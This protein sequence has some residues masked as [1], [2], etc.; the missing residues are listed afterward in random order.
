MFEEEIPHFSEFNEMTDD[1]LRGI[2]IAR[3][4]TSTE[5]AKVEH[6]L[7]RIF[8]WAIVTK[9]KD[10][11]ISSKGDRNQP[12]VLFSIDQPSGL[13][14]LTYIGES[15]KT[16][17]SKMF[18]LTNTPQG[19]STTENVSTRFSMNLPNW[20]A[21]KHGLEPV[22]KEDYYI[23]LRV[24]YHRTFDG[25]AFVCRLLD[26]Q[27]A[28][29]LNEFGL[30][31]SVYDCIVRTIKMP[32]GLVIVSGPPGSGKSTLLNAIVHFRNDGK[33]PIL[34]IED[35]VEFRIRS[36]GPVN[37]INVGGNVTFASA[38]KASLRMAVKIILVGEI[39]DAETMK[40]ALQATQAGHLVLA[41]LHASNAIETVSRARD[42]IS[43]DAA[44]I[45]R[46]GNALKLVIAARLINKYEGHYQGR[47]V[48]YDEKEWLIDNGIFY[49]DPNRKHVEDSALI[50]RMIISEVFSTQESK[51]KVSVVE[52]FTVDHSI[53][54]LIADKVF[55]TDEMYKKIVNQIQYES[56]PLCGYRAVESKKCKLS[57]C[58]TVLEAVTS[59]KVIPNLR[60]K[61]AYEFELSL[62]EVNE[63]IENFIV[64]RKNGSDQKVEYFLVEMQRCKR[65]AS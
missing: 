49:Q 65:L 48:S 37:Q 31:A 39:R 14:N 58:Q 9:S 24:E 50:S 56:L 13:V 54:N 16:F 12:N 34:T 8:V 47:Q 38:L 64:A 44:E 55:N 3:R 52:A 28:P 32:S 63:A 15:G 17:E 11:H 20:F 61:Y 7:R 22:E 21:V 2:M 6:W 30:S 1:E 4:D 41:T 53:K 42:L 59:A 25:F 26:Q 36:S 35:P 46:L 51:E 27:R 57:D 33:T 45:A 40:I 10:V 29:K 60:S 5:D 18:S 19:G 23:D 43:N 62:T